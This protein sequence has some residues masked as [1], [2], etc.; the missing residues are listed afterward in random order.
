MV[1][2]YRNRFYQKT[3]KEGT[4]MHIA[5]CDDNVADRKQLERLLQRESDKQYGIREPF[6]I[7]SYGNAQA[8]MRSPMLY[9]AFF[10]DMTASEKNGY[11]VAMALIHAGVTVP[12]ILCI[13]TINYRDFNLPDNCFFL[14]KAIRLNELCDMLEM[15]IVSCDNRV[16]H[17]EIRTET[18]THYV[19]ENDIMYFTQSAH[20]LI[21]LSDGRVLEVNDSLVN[22]YDGVRNMIC[23]LPISYKAVVNVSYISNMSPFSV[24]TKDG[25]KFFLH[26]A[27]CKYA[28]HLMKQ[29]HIKE[30]SSKEQ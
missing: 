6:Y 7:D 1:L 18:D 17:I 24:Q 29:Y 23:F 21:Y 11:E 5:I 3:G 4:L 15:L 13:S 28:H 26:P 20:T 25:R 27:F 30:I 10:I 14:Q 19:T 16:P 9:D 2:L 8:L 12:I 22:F